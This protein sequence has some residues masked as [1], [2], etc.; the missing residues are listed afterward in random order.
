[1]TTLPAGIRVRLPQSWTSDQEGQNN[2]GSLL[3]SVV[4]A[5]LFVDIAVLLTWRGPAQRPK[6]STAAVP[7]LSTA[8][9]PADVAIDDGGALATGTT[10]ANG[11]LLGIA[12]GLPST[13]KTTGL[14]P[15]VQSGVVRVP[16]GSA[17]ATTPASLAPLL[18]ATPAFLANNNGTSG[19]VPSSTATGPA[20]AATAPTLTTPTVS[21][22]S[23]STPAGTTPAVTVPSLTTPSVSVPVPTSIPNAGVPTV[24]VP[25]VSTP[26]GTT[27]SVT[28]PTVT[29]P[30]TAAPEPVPTTTP[31]TTAP[32]LPVSVPTVTVPTV[33]VPPTP[34]ATPQA[35][36]PHLS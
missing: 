30:S 13:T 1:M 25:S 7:E 35:T 8:A 36:A 9:V 21:V 10:L 17:P 5:L 20:T 11:K 14:I 23:I 27:P 6:L 34:A 2:I 32:T 29:T 3:A 19:S 22:P 24:S 33:T 16:E 4:A 31:A 26:V 15:A 28:V 12:G 18:G